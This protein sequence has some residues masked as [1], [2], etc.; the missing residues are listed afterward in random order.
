M[1][2]ANNPTPSTETHNVFHTQQQQQQDY[3]M[4]EG[5]ETDSD[6]LHDTRPNRWRGQPST[7]RGWTE[8][9]RQ[10][11]TALENERKGDLAVHLFNAFG[12]RRGFRVGPVSVA[13][14]GEVCLLSFSR[15]YLFLIW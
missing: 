4:N 3:D 5:N 13:V 11:W 7:W 8:A 12:L 14:A 10:T 6:E 2:D 1:S 9:D 15:F